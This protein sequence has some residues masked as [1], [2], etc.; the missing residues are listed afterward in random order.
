[1]VVMGRGIKEVMGI[2]TV[3]ILSL[4]RSVEQQCSCSMEC[5][6]RVAAGPVHEY[7]SWAD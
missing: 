6:V 4:G 5:I 7:Q 1:M 2:V 3:R